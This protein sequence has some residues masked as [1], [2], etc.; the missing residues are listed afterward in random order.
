M[1]SV[2]FSEIAELFHQVCIYFVNI[3]I[4]KSYNNYQF[5]S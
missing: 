5:E 3:N 1:H 4:Y 2:F